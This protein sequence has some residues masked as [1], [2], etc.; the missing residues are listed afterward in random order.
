MELDAL[1]F[2]GE[3]CHQSRGGLWK[4]RKQCLKIIFFGKERNCE[5]IKFL[6]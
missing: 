1:G 4:Y 3:W 2:C 5:R 6:L